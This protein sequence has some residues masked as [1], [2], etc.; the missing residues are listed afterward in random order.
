MAFT[1]RRALVAAVGGLAV[2]PGCG[3]ITG[4]EPARFAAEPA[5]VSD[6]A[7][8]D[9]NY[10]ERSVSEEVRTR[11]FSAGG[12]SRSVEVTNQ[13]ARY[14]RRVDLGPLGSVRAAV[15]TALTS[16][17]VEVLGETFNPLADLSEREIIDRFDSEYESVS[18]DD[19]VGRRDAQVLGQATTV[20]KYD[21]TAEI[22]GGTVDVYVHVTKLRHMDDFVVVVAVYP[23]RLSDEESNVFRLLSGLQHTGG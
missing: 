18:V 17:A 2:L 7:R 23:Q 3:F 5:T 1:R 16:P 8:S 14:E 15:F 11:E 19:R 13:L 10:E 9:A 4:D 6:T 21:G 12:E 20:E 22:A